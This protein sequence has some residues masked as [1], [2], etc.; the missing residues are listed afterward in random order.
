MDSVLWSKLFRVST[1]LLKNK[2]TLIYRGTKDGFGAIDFHREC[3]GVAK[4]VTIVKTTNGNIFG[5]YTD[6]TWSSPTTLTD[7]IDNN[8]F[9]FS[10]VNEKNQQFISMPKNNQ[11]SIC[12]YSGYGPVFGNKQSN[13]DIC[14]ASN[15]NMNTSSSS[16]LG[17]SFERTDIS[18]DTQLIL[19][20]SQNFQTVEVEVYRIN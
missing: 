1:K 5:G 16:V 6:L 11:G 17:S 19:A 15:S 13:R 9:I 10:L 20:G 7:Y 12:C 18:H 4:T 2:W 3:D 8:A 14:I